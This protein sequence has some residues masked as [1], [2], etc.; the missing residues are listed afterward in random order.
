MHDKQHD[1]QG[2]QPKNGIVEPPRSPPCVA[3]SIG[4]FTFAPDTLRREF[5]N[6]GEDHDQR[7][8]G[9]TY[10][11]HY[12]WEP[13]RQVQQRGDRVRNLDDKPAKRQVGHADLQDIAAFQFGEE[14]QLPGSC[15]PLRDFMVSGCRSITNHFGPVT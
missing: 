1:R 10:P 2:Q 14:R 15:K 4:D 6:P 13:P 8:A 7:E 11:E 9:Y 3:I 5:V 12:L